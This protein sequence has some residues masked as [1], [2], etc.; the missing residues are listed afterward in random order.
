MY[1]KAGAWK[2]AQAA[3][4]AS[5]ELALYEIPLQALVDLARQLKEATEIADT[6][7]KLA[8]FYTDQGKIDLAIEKLKEVF[9]V[10]Q[11]PKILEKLEALY[12]QEGGEDSQSKLQ[13]LAI[14]RF[15]LQLSQEP[16]TIK[17][18]RRY[19]QFLKDIGR[20][21]EARAVKER[22]DER[23]QQ[24]L[25]NQKIK[26]VDLKQT[27]HLQTKS[28]HTLDTQVKILSKQLEC[29]E[30]QTVTLNF[31]HFPNIRDEELIPLLRKHPFI[32]S[33]RLEGCAYL[34]DAVLHILAEHSRNLKKL[35]LSGC[36]GITE[37]GLNTMVENV[38]RLKR[39]ILDDCPGTTIKLLHKL[40]AKGIAFSIEGVVFKDKNLDLSYRKE[41]LTDD[42][43]LEILNLEENF[44]VTKLSLRGC[45]SITDAGLAPL[46]NF[47]W[48][49]SLD[50][51]ACNRLTDKG[52]QYI[53][54]F[55]RLKTLCLHGTQ[56]TGDGLSQL[57]GVK[58]LAYLGLYNCQNITD[59]GLSQFLAL[60]QFTQLTSL[61]LESCNQ[62]TD[63]GLRQILGLSQ[64]KT[65]WLMG[66]QITDTSLGII[67]GLQQISHLS[68]C[69]C[70]NITDAGLRKLSGLKQLAQL[71]L[72]N[73]NNIKAGA[74]EALKKALPEL[75]IQD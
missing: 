7:G 72:R 61:N 64:L 22:M 12:L 63:E 60:N 30:R 29:L 13:E 58:Q 23:L 8:D 4:R 1:S 69:G 36:K 66:V 18:Y 28:I 59:A 56:V 48:L 37:A 62:L 47:Q 2:E 57:S 49:T 27:T 9:E 25:L 54:G 10:M 16:K 31:S 50:L 52:L 65:L 5:C 11:S 45:T 74:K 44:E 15:E 19:A 26:I 32:K 55:S 34:T 46:K 6:L 75:R 43:F 3:Y 14:Q 33:L 39:L 38:P 53:K 67:S 41:T 21:N 70:P 35:N 73:L 17:V 40:N 68:L 20:K 24:K 71:E 42:A 51:C